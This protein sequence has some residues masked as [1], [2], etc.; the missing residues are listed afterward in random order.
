VRDSIQ[1]GLRRL[2]RVIASGGIAAGMV[3]VLLRFTGD[4]QTGH[5]QSP[6]SPDETT[7]KDACPTDTE[8]LKAEGLSRAFRRAAQN[9]L[10][11]VVVIKAG[12]SPVCPQCGRA[13]EAYDDESDEGNADA[14]HQRPLDV[15]GSGFIVAPTG[16]VLTNK[17]VVKGNP[18]LVVQTADGKQFPVKQVSTDREYDA[19]V[20]RIDASAPLPFVRLGDSEAAEIGDWV[21]TIGS[22]LEL[23]QTVSAGIISAKNRSLCPTH[24]ANY[25]Q[26]DAVV[27]PGSSG[28]PLVALNGSVIG[29]TTAIASGD[30]GYQGIGFAIPSNLVKRLVTK[31]TESVPRDPS[32]RDSGERP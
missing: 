7:Q 28:G 9:V 21:L 3:L 11:A 32:P 8:V 31:F 14:G 23:D 30:G 29:I 22:P 24:Q 5:A 15:L 12:P 6:A 25:L 17:H 27:N 13:H 26:T 16:V 18:R 2:F 20:L 4:R 10:P 19:A 1:A